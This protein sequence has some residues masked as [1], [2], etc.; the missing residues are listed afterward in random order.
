VL[1]GVNTEK[2]NV[3]VPAFEVGTPLADS[4]LYCVKVTDHV[5]LERSKHRSEF[6]T[7]VVF[8]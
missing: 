1:L 8:T 6:G 7:L 2:E 5:S 3:F 4:A